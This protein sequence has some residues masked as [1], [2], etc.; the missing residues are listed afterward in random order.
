MLRLT[1]AMML[2]LAAALTGACG[3]DDPATPTE[4]SPTE[5]T[6]VFSG[7]LTVNGAVTHT[8]EVQ[9]AGTATVRI[10]S[11]DPSAAVIGLSMGPFTGQACVQQLARDN[12]TSGAS[13]AGSASSGAFCV[14]VYDAGDTLTGPVSYELTVT[15]F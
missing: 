6:E 10:T 8:F 5:I 2:A 13:I 14:R 15:H 7:T 9:R 1:F 4:P 3:D 11:L 12:A